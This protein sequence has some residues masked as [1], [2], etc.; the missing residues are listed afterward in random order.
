MWFVTWGSVPQRTVFPLKSPQRRVFQLFHSLQQWPR[1]TSVPSLST[2]DQSLRKTNHKYKGLLLA[3]Q[4][5]ESQYSTF[6]WTQEVAHTFFSMILTNDW[7]SSGF[8]VDGWRDDISISP[9][10]TIFWCQSF[11]KCARYYVVACSCTLFMLSWNR[12]YSSVSKFSRSDF[13]MLLGEVS[14]RSFE[15]TICGW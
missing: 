8:C 13:M 5:N 10:L 3:L 15:P 7:M 14:V 1:P 4:I 6:K 9:Y 12:C 2:K 11:V